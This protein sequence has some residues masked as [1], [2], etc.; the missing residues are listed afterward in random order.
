L[1]DAVSYEK[2]HPVYFADVLPRPSSQM[3]RDLLLAMGRKQE[4]CAA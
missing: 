1:T 2:S 4:A 3:L